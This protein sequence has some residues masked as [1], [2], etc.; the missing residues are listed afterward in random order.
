M[1][2]KNA[3]Q[4]ET[5]NDCRIAPFSAC[6]AGICLDPKASAGQGGEGSCTGPAGCFR[7]APQSNDELLNAC[8]DRTCVPF[9]NSKRLQNLGTDGKLK[10]LLER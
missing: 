7:C 3:T 2:D 5:D 4:C 9:D 1:I 8:T 10:P 6:S